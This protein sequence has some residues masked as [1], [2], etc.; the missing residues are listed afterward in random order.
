MRAKAGRHRGVEHAELLDLSSL[1]ETP[2]ELRLLESLQQG[3]V[4]LLRRGEI[5]RQRLKLLL[6]LRRVF[7]PLLVGGDR[8]FQRRLLVLERPQ[9]D[10]GVRDLRLQA[11]PGVG[12]ARLRI[13]SMRIHRRLIER[14]ELAANANH[15]GILVGKL[16]KKLC[17][18]LFQLR[19]LILR[20]VGLRRA[21]RRH[22][23]EIGELF[24]EAVAAVHRPDLVLAVQAQLG[25][26]P[27]EAGEV[28]VDLL[29]QLAEVAKL[30][31]ALSVLL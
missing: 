26:E 18:T 23:V 22:G 2:G 30:V 9:L 15:L 8:H 10:V 25:V 27:L 24:L 12:S 1:F 28:H 7:D 11:L 17:E 16:G 4:A 6:A 3:L 20:R 29:R 13:S 14:R 21:R 31:F 5:A 19:A